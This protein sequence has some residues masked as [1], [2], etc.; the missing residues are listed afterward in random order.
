MNRTVGG[1]LRSVTLWP[2]CS[3]RRDFPLGTAPAVMAA[4]TVYS[5]GSYAA[6]NGDRMSFLLQLPL[7]LQGAT[8]ADGTTLDNGFHVFTLIYAANR[9]MQQCGGSDAAW[10]ACRD[11]F[12]MGLFPRSG[13]AVYGGSDVRSIPGNDFLVVLLSKL[14]GHDWRPYWDVR[15]VPYSDLASAQVDALPR[16]NGRVSTD[17]WALGVD[18]PQRELRAG[19]LSVRLDGASAWPTDD[20]W[21]PIFSCDAAYTRTRTRS[22]SVTP[23]R[24]P[25]G[26]LTPS[27]PPTVTSRP[28]GSPSAAVTL[29]PGASPSGTPSPAPSGPVSLRITGPAGAC[30]SLQEVLVFDTDARLI[31]ATSGRLSAGASASWGSG[32]STAWSSDAWAA[33]DGSVGMTNAGGALWGVRG[34]AACPSS[35]SL[36]LSWQLSL[37]ALLASPG[38]RI[39][40]IYVITTPTG[41]GGAAFAAGTNVTLHMADGSQAPG[42]RWPLKAQAVTW[43]PVAPVSPASALPSTDPSR[44]SSWVRYVRLSVPNY[45]H[46]KELF[47]LS[48]SGVNVALGKPVSGGSQYTGDAGQVYTLAAG[49]NGIIDACDSASSSCVRDLVHT[50]SY[51]ASDWEVDLG[52]VYNVAQVIL[53]NRAGGSASRMTG[54][55]LQFYDANRA[56]VDSRPT[57]EDHIRSFA[58]ELPA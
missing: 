21:H 54:G 35:P 27:N 25:T 31:S 1:V 49:V 26:S 36:Q 18:L 5:D 39:G 19:V 15:G 22:P 46:F 4:E 44:Q 14:S 8:L 2:D 42:A 56:L 3:V 51:W 10:L 23:S 57:T 20:G 33:A 43:I 9:L 40:A 50:S 32:A 34:A 6:D 45:L 52:G 28:S 12:G 17:F 37:P 24:S 38:A 13:H 29:A 55:S 47:V 58:L 48:S 7:I 30:L 41:G 16:P 53:L 11:R